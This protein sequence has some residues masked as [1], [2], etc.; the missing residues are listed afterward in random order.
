MTIYYMPKLSEML[1]I[2]NIPIEIDE[3]SPKTFSSDYSGIFNPFYG[4][5][6]T[7]EFK[8][9]ISSVHK[10]KIVSLETRKKMSDSQQNKIVSLETRKKLSA[11]K[12]GNTNRRGK[13]ASSETREKMRLA[14]LGK[15]RP[16]HSEKMSGK[17]HP[18]FGKK[19]STETKIK[20]S[21]SRKQH[22]MNNTVN[23]MN[24]ENF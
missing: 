8:L 6:H 17:N 7:E 11:S 14:K 15:R 9:F 10:N 2:P 24:K 16:T 5:P 1:N 22:Y 4:K 12:I 13:I 19:L 23:N 3:E 18:N 20:I 21:E